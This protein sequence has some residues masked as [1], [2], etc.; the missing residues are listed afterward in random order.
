MSD[1]RFDLENLDPN[2]SHEAR[3]AI[4]DLILAWASYDSL[5]SQ[6]IIVSFALPMDAGA[7]LVGNMDTRTKLD[8]LEYL[9]RH[10]GMSGADAIQSLRKDHLSHVS[11]R[12]N[13]CHSHC[14][15]SFKSDPKR[16]VFAP[17][18]TVKGE[19]GHM[20]FEAVHLDQIT[21]A[22]AFALDACR[23]LNRL[24]EA[25]LEQRK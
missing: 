24:V 9:Y 5:V 25:A 10:Q 17:V 16:I 1:P 12:N 19:P 7:I 8:R 21:E 2:I 15:G 11:V 4:C 3:D 14:A 6:W 18:K 23:F 22:T 13:I 20:L